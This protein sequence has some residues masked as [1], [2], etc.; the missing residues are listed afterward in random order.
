MRLGFSVGVLGATGLPSYDARV[1]P[2]A[3]DLGVS[4]VCLRDILRYLHSRDL[5]M[6]RMHSGLVW[7]VSRSGEAPERVLQRYARDLALVGGIAVEYDVRL[8]FHPYSIVTLSTPNEDQAR[9]GE[10]LLTTQALWMDA[11]GLGPQAV[12]VVHVGGVYDDLEHSQRRF[13][14][15]FQA[16]DACVRRRVVLENDDHRFSFAAVRHIYDACGIP[17]VF[18][19]LHHAV[20]NPEGVPWRVALAFALGT[21]PIGVKPKVHFSSPR[22]EL[23][24]LG[25]TG[26][27]KAPTWTEHSDFCN[28]FEFVA[29]LQAAADMQAF[30]VMLEAKARD[31]AVQQI[32]EDLR[33]FA[34]SLQEEGR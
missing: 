15:R 34:P 21:W 22:T 16:L 25:A 28:P 5:N 17:L 27:W 8:S 33:R 31:L 14:E 19:Y 18:D 30:D 23:R 3:A 1:V 10:R 29:F 32:R 7:P 24:R 12:I 4:L 6:Y 20:H 11:L 13:V 9:Q 2:A 26:R